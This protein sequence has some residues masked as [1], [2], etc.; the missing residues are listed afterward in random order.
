[1]NRFGPY[2]VQPIVAGLENGKPVIATYDSI[3]CTS[4]N[5]PYQVGGTGGDEL[6]GSCESYWKPDMEP[7]YLE[8]VVA[9]TLLSG[10]DRDIMS[11]WGGIV[12]TL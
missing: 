1:M 7:D 8:E 2:F 6:L 12:Y 4:D 11:G 9:Q 3:G 5:E 10:C